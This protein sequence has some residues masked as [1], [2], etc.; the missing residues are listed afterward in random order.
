MVLQLLQ[1]VFN[2]TKR[3][4]HPFACKQPIPRKRVETSWGIAEA[5]GEDV[6]P[7]LGAVRDIVKG[8]VLDAVERNVPLRVGSK[9]VFKLPH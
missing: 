7:E 6:I 8:A 9:E 2:D 1:S 4:R 3:C 5:K